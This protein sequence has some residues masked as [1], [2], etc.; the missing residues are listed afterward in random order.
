M[1]S[2]RHDEKTGSTERARYLFKITIVGPDDELLGKVLEVF[3]DTTLAVDGIRIGSTR[4]AVSGSEVGTV[5]MSPGKT[6][7][8]LLL[9]LSYKGSAGAIIVLKNADPQ[10]EEFYRNEARKNLGAQSPI[11]VF[12]VDSG[13][14]KEKKAELVC[15]LD[16]IVTEIIQKRFSGVPPM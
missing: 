2:K 7:Q 15:L 13:M 6:A 10:T 3:S 5:L 1:G 8:S 11:R 14:T 16:N 9:T 12:V 4:V